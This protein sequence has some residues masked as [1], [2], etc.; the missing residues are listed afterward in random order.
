MQSEINLQ[1]KKPNMSQ[2]PTALTNALRDLQRH[3][4]QGLPSADQVMQASNGSNWSG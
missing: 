4:A 2:V 3:G 1:G